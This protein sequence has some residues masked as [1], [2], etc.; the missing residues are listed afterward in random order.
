V[1]ALGRVAIAI[2]SRMSLLGRH[3]PRPLTRT[4]CIRA[5][6]SRHA[7][8][9]MHT[10][11]AARIMD[12]GGGSWMERT[13]SSVAS[14]RWRDPV[15][16]LAAFGQPSRTRPLDWRGLQAVALQGLHGG[17][18]LT[19]RRTCRHA[20]PIW[21]FRGPSPRQKLPWGHRDPSMRLPCDE[22]DRQWLFCTSAFV[23]KAQAA[24]VK[25]RRDL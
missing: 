19:G 18:L 23:P 21:G 1:P 6:A 10:T 17:P 24:A 13:T 14:H 5:D 20:R 2:G 12:A 15:G 8:P 22:R 4:R 25:N 3:G 16:L 9:H 7:R 11:H